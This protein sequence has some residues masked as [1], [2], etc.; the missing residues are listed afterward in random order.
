[1][2]IIVR[3]EEPPISIPILFPSALLFNHVTAVLLLLVMLCMQLC[4][5]TPWRK[6]SPLAGCSPFHIFSAF[7][8]FIFAYWR[9]RICNPGWELVRV[10]S[11]DARVTIKL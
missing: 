5:C 11:R 6:V 10:T 2:R 4:G 3:T 1:M 9:C 8:R 7:S